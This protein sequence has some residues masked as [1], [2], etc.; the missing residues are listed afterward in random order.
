MVSRA[1]PQLGD[2]HAPEQPERRQPPLALVDRG[3]LNGSPGFDLQLALDRLGAG[4]HV[5]DDQHVVDEHLRPFADE[6][7]DIDTRAVL[8]ELGSRL[9]DGALW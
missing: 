3:R 4:P 9:D 8:G 5:A 1:V 7:R 6:K 2:P